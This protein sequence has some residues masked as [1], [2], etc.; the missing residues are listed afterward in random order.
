MP[1][2]YA[3]FN[4]RWVRSLLV[5]VVVAAAIPLLGTAADASFPGRNG[6][7]LAQ[8]P[9]VDVSELA[10][11][12]YVPTDGGAPRVL[13]LGQSPAWSP[14]G[15]V[16]A[17]SAFRKIYVATT[18]GYR[19]TSHRRLITVPRRIQLWELSWFPGGNRLAY[20]AL[21][22]KTDTSDIHTLRVSDGRHRSR[23]TFARKGW[24]NEWPAV[25]PNGRRVAYVQCSPR[26]R[27]CN[28]RLMRSNGEDQHTIVSVPPWRVV[29]PVWAPG[30]RNIGFSLCGLHRCSAWIYNLAT[31]RRR[32]VPGDTIEAFAPDGAHLLVLDDV[33]SRPE[34]GEGLFVTDLHGKDRRLL[35]GDCLAWADWQAFR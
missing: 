21:D 2:F 35:P 30:G 17:F 33:K 29:D 19:L 13:G 24:S 18:D 20:V 11:L 1:G 4:L 16:F 32:R 31:H 5:L 10:T 12:V 23:L 14:R 25:S 6:A 7:I 15:T 34:C 8:G 28:L 9:P 3:C 27:A 22:M 26:E